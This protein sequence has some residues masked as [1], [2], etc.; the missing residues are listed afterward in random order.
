MEVYLSSKDRFVRVVFKGAI[1]SLVLCFVL[2]K[3]H[4]CALAWFFA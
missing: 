2:G 3:K 4:P 1:S